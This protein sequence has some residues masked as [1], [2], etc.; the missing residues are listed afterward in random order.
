[1]SLEI[2]AFICTF[3][4]PYGTSAI[5]GLQCTFEA[6]H[7]C[8]RISQSPSRSQT[9]TRNCKCRFL[10]TNATWS[11]EVWSAFTIDNV[12]PRQSNKAFALSRCVERTHSV[13]SNGANFGASFGFANGAL[14]GTLQLKLEQHFHIC[15][16]E[17]SA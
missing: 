11:T 1:M 12:Y 2:L 3:P 5:S 10:L 15:A 17:L 16:I 8:F 6:F 4:G 9:M 7:G 13:V 14:A